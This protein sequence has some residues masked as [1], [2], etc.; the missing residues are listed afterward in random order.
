VPGYMI[1]Y[2]IRKYTSYLSRVQHE[3]TPYEDVDS[4]KHEGRALLEA[5][6]YPRY[7]L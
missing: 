5:K 6:S 3:P 1:Q 4:S 7:L 2:Y